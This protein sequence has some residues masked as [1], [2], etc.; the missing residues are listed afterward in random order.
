VRT[1][2][3]AVLCASFASTPWAQPADVAEPARQ[4]VGKWLGRIDGD[5]RARSLAVT[6]LAP[7][8]E[9]VFAIQATYGFADGRQEPIAGEFRP[10]EGRLVFVT[11]ARSK[12]EM[13]RLNDRAFEGLFS[14]ARG[15]ARPMT[16]NR[17]TDEELQA[18]AFP[19]PGSNVPESCAG[20]FGGWDGRWN[21]RDPGP[22]KLW[23]VSIQ[24]D[25]KVRYAYNS[26]DSTAMPTSFRNAEIRDGV[27][28]VG[29][30]G[31]GTCSFRRQND[32]IWGSYT[33]PLGA[34]NTAV[35]RRL[36]PG[37]RP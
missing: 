29:C 24:P 23:V 4:V 17:A 18:A 31:G 12:V 30:A 5:P 36:P 26:T 7:K 15:E 27:L 1:F 3:A 32:Q 19:K 28:T 34:T 13:T 8:T 10:A 22:Q 16:L 6:G 21:E 35:F 20:F 37:D 9:T 33:N 14:P 2:A 11:P 25:C